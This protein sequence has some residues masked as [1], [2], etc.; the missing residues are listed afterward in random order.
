MTYFVFIDET[1]K[2][3]DIEK[4]LEKGN[5][6]KYILASIMVHVS[7]I[8]SYN[9]LVRKFINRRI[10][11]LIGS[12]NIEIHGKCILAPN[13]RSIWSNISLDE[14]I[15]LFRDLFKDVIA[16]MDKIIVH[17]VG[18]HSE[19]VIKHTTEFSLDPATN[20]YPCKDI[21]IGKRDSKET[22]TTA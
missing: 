8:E 19:A 14:R 9:G 11:P 13:K 16:K 15:R 10:E 21:I 22:S 5:G 3:S 7:H 12:P 4:A 1:G 2:S 20:Q 17:V 6:A 18:M